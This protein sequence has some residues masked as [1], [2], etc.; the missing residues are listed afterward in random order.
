[1]K[2]SFALNFSHDG[3]SLLHRVPGG[4]QRVDSVSLDDPEIDEK[5]RVMRKTANSLDAGRLA[6]KLVIPN[7]QILYT[8]VTA[9][10]PSD[11]ERYEQI[12]GSL[13][14][15]TPYAID[16]LAFDWDASG[17]ICAVAAVAL[18][19]LA[20]AESFAVSHKFNPV[21]FVA[22]PEGDSFRG[23]PFF[24][25]AKAADTVLNGAEVVD[26]DTQR[27]VVLGNA[28]PAKPD[29]GESD[30]SAAETS[31]EDAK[32][33]TFTSTFQTRREDTDGSAASPNAPEITVS[34]P[35]RIS[36]VPVGAPTAKPEAA[37][38]ATPK[39]A[40]AS[41]ATQGSEPGKRSVPVPPPPLDKKDTLVLEN[42][43]AGPVT[44]PVAPLAARLGSAAKGTNG[45]AAPIAKKTADEPPA[46]A[47]PKAAKVYSSAEGRLSP[48][49]D[50]AEALTVFGARKKASQRGKPRYLGLILTAIL[51]AFLAAVALWSSSF[52]SGGIT[53]LFFRQ[54]PVV[55]DNPEAAADE[56]AIELAMADPQEAIEPGPQIA[57]I[58]LP[59]L[60]ATVDAE[61]APQVPDPAFA[62]PDADEAGAIYARTGVWVLPP[63]PAPEPQEENLD[64]LYIASIEPVLASLDAIALPEI[65]GAR[66]QSPG[67]MLPPVALGTVV[68]LD[69]NGRTIPSAQ[70]SFS[71]DGILIYAG[72]P[73]SVPPVRPRTEAP[74]VEV[75]V[76]ALPRIVPRPRPENLAERV[77]R[78]QFGGKTREEMASLRPSPRP[79]SEQIAAAAALKTQAP[80]KLAVSVSRAPSPRPSNMAVLVSVAR[81][82]VPEPSAPTKEELEPEAEA[83][84]ASVAPQ[85][86]PNIPTHASV[87]RRATVPNAIHLRQVNLIGVY[88]TASDR[89]ALVRLSNGRYIKVSVGDRVDGGKVSAI[90]EDEL[91]Y[92]KRG[93]NITLKMPSG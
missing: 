27:I 71:P 3:I 25:L 86:A 88:G 44:P 20:E 15:L 84:V 35:A 17:D 74:E 73:K 89:R 23:E 77:E 10:G 33:P 14:G 26:R 42:G 7:S 93:K 58:E 52:V 78:Q 37:E 79:Q 28:K 4:W 2:P 85:T 16:E 65:V 30:E 49:A 68:E 41:G 31:Q 66:D 39:E 83:A 36:F 51:L 46:K 80:S 11:A 60:E 62:L 13:D 76:A 72:K 75:A 56:A 29:A 38:K 61:P 5:L 59:S 24:G 45:A 21:S 91:R 43:D 87:A 69:D 8:S 12:R 70:G 64:N 18:E 55:A 92:I 50:E 47:A 67:E 90:G 54:D 40:V 81:A 63:D 82:R 53:E 19:T 9:P 1:M 57:P 34:A 22:T 32:R 48:P 6:C